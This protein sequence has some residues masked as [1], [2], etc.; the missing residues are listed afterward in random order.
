MMGDWFL[1]R[2]NVIWAIRIPSR[3]KTYH[4]IIKELCIS[5]RNPFLETLGYH[6]TISRFCRNSEIF[7]LFPTQASTS[8]FS[9]LILL[10]ISGINTCNATSLHFHVYIQ[11]L[12]LISS[13]LININPKQSKKFGTKIFFYI[14]HRYK[15]NNV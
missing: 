8:L 9:E 3:F 14:S 2:K 1:K 5:A 11:T 7:C 6:Y 12:D 10:S 15:I 4:R 13:Q